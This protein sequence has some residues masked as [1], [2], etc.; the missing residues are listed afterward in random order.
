MLPPVNPGR[1]QRQFY[2]CEPKHTQGGTGTVSVQTV[3]GY[4]HHLPSTLLPCTNLL[5]SP[6]NPQLRRYKGTTSPCLFFGGLLWMQNPADS[7]ISVP[8]AALAFQQCA[9]HSS[10]FVC[11]ADQCI[12][13][14]LDPFSHP[15]PSYCCSCPMPP[16]LLYS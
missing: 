10:A 9:V 15:I 3:G 7:A 12:C 2:P 16:Q 14:W 6:L 5:S 4:P 11:W 1:L 8:C 13:T